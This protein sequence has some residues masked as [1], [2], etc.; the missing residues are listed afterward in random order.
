MQVKKKTSS[1]LKYPKSHEAC[2]WQG[3]YLF[4]DLTSKESLGAFQ[5]KI[6]MFNSVYRKYFKVKHTVERESS[7]PSVLTLQPL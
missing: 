2:E 5:M 3:V 1:L 4:P 6:K 7:L